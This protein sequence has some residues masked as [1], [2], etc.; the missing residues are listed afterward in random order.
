MERKKC[1]SNL[2][3]KPLVE[4]I[5]ELKWGIETE[6]DHGYP[7]IVGRLYEK[8]KEEFPHIEDL[9]IN[10]IPPDLSVHI[11]RHRFRKAENTW[12]LVQVGPGILTL[13][14]TAGYDWESFRLRAN[15][16]FPLL[17]DLHPL[18]K[19]LRITSLLLR[20]INGI[21]IDYLGLNILDELKDKL[22]ISISLP[23]ELMEGL[24][25]QG[26]PSGLQLQLGI[27][28]ANPT[29]VSVTRFTTGKLKDK[30]AIIWELQFL[31]E[32]GPADNLKNIFNEWL[33]AAHAIIEHWFF[34]LSKGKL[35]EEFQKEKP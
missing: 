23:R 1:P 33:D 20:Y 15:R 14:E 35:L 8:V 24:P 21:P 32:G 10:V 13:N 11:V 34:Q 31:S 29:G 4:A 5:V 17:F 19:D 7:L 12:P 18:G 16:V 2:P 3:N 26:K 27:P 28:S 22:H 9:P 30:P 6:P 25:L